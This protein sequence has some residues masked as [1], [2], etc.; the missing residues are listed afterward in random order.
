MPDFV[1]KQALE[2]SFE[3]SHHR[4]AGCF[5]ITQ[6]LEAVPEYKMGIAGVEYPDKRRIGPLPV[7]LQQILVAE[8]GKLILGYVAYWG[9]VMLT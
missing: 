8:I 4:V 5:W 9:H 3:N 6:V 1:P 2:Q 7:P